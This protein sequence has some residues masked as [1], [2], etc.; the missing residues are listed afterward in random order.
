MGAMVMDRAA[1]L[2][3]SRGDEMLVATVVAVNEMDLTVKIIEMRQHKRRNEIAA[4]Y[5]QLRALLIGQRDRT[6]EMRDVIVGIGTD[7]NAHN[8][9][10]QSARMAGCSVWLGSE[11]YNRYRPGKILPFFTLIA[12]WGQRISSCSASASAL[13]PEK[14]SS[15]VSI[16]FYYCRITSVPGAMSIL[17]KVC[18]CC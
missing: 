8:D 15:N 14:R 13:S 2:A 12:P 10:G 5:Q 11:V 18:T 7:G 6:S 3:A 9:H 1:G 4:V 17:S 16:L